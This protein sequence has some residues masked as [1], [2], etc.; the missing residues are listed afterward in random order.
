VSLWVKMIGDS[1]R[2]TLGCAAVLW[3]GGKDSCLALHEALLQGLRVE[4]LVTF[5]PAE[6]RFHA[7]PLP[8]Q[9]L[10]ARA[11]GLSHH[12][13]EIHE[14]YETTYRNAMSTLRQR[15]GIDTLVTGDIAEV[16]GHPN[17]IRQCCAGSHTAVLTPLWGHDGR[18]LLDRF[19]SAGFKAIFS[20]VREPWL[21][22]EWL[23]REL[24]TA[25]VAELSLLARRRGLDV[26]GEQGEYHTLVLDGPL[27]AQRICIDGCLTKTGENLS[28]LDSL[29]LSLGGG[30]GVP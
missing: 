24:D 8:V 3:T 12:V 4:H 16:N 19:V 6:A 18:E 29:E 21:T 23:G 27:F 25:A 9:Q 5:A 22:P 7:H 28:Y 26:C 15:W 1:P 17:W 20:C 14:P 30:Q 11:L 2:H 10:Q 13:L